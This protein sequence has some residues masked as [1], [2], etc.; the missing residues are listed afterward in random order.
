MQ[1]FLIDALSYLGYILP[2]AVV[3]LMAYNYFKAYTKGEENRLKHLLQK[4]TISQTLPLR[5]Q[6]YERLTLF[7]ERIEPNKILL[8]AKP[9][10]DK[11]KDYESLL[12]RTIEQ[13]FEHN[14]SQQIYISNDAWSLILTAKH[15]YIQLIRK[16]VLEN[17]QASPNEFREKLLSKFLN[18]LSPSQKALV[19]LKEEVAELW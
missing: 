17:D 10:N 8:R 11:L 18:E 1:D 15:A 9:L 16:T 12:I 7:L 5:L 19:Y 2:A 4:K 13:E 6:A 14:L 3:G